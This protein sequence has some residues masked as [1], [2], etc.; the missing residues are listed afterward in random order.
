MFGSKVGAIKGN[1]TKVNNVEV[2][3]LY[4]SSNIVRIIK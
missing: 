4:S 3:D 2:H 1:Y